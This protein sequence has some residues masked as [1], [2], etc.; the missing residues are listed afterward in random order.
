MVHAK[1]HDDLVKFYTGERSGKP[2]I[3]E[4]WENGGSHGDSVTPSTYS[5][6]YREWMTELLV[7]RLRLGGG[8]LLSLGCGNAA[9][10]AQVQHLGFRVLAIDAM[11]DAVDLARSK[12]V[13]AICADIYEWEPEETFPVIYIDGVL[14]HLNDDDEGLVPVLD[15]IRS[16]LTPRDGDATMIA[17]NDMPKDDVPVQ[18][19]PGV[20]GF[21]W[22][23]G[24][25][26]GAQAMKAGFGSVDVTEFR[27]R[28][29]IS[30][31]RMRAVVAAQL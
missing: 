10:E 3:F 8:R 20:N 21:S 13:E 24:E 7:S 22:L 19:A 14:G 6:A 27:Y 1:N 15:R 12:G 11:Q 31:D 29:P 9:V 17:S 23:S 26:I 4:V 18:R 5:P 2:N 30:G 25:Y 28:R 16:W